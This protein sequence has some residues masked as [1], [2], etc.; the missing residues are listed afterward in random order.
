MKCFREG[1]GKLKSYW[2]KEIYVVV[3]CDPDLPIYKIKRK[4]GSKPIRTIHRNLLLQCNEL[5]FKTSSPYLKLKIS[6]PQKPSTS[7]ESQTK[8]ESE[9]D[10]E[11]V[12][13]EKP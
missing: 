7:A 12:L 9:S 6:S 3:P 11:F 13:T 4:N 1:T 10:S 2:E 8:F 5:P